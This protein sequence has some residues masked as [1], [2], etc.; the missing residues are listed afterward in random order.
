MESNATKRHRKKTIENAPGQFLMTRNMLEGAA[1]SK[2]DTLA[3]KICAQPGRGADG[4]ETDPPGETEVTY[5]NVLRAFTRSFFKPVS[6]SLLTQR[7]YLQHGIKFPVHREVELRE[8][9]QRLYVIN[10]KS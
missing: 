6:D 7:E 9:L 4:K 1:K 2:F 3:A 5:K 10:T 8:W